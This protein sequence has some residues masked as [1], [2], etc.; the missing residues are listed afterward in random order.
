MRKLILLFIFAVCCTLSK[1]QFITGLDEVALLGT[2]A[3]QGYAEDADNVWSSM[4]NKR[5]SGIKFAD[6]GIT[7]IT[8]QD[9]N[10]SRSY[11]ISFYGY[12][13]GGTATGKYTLHFIQQA[14]SETWDYVTPQLNFVI[15]SFD[16]ESI[17]LT[18]YDGK[19]G[20]IMQKY[21]SGVENVSADRPETS[22]LLYD[23]NG[24]AVKNPTTHG[25]YIQGDGK[26]IIK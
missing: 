11:V 24:L 2:W 14:E 26:K 4:Q 8:V 7:S 9:D 5:L 1:A 16:S 13:I 12:I 21:N 20:V 6:D 22:S 19:H 15:T 10:A 18:S 23:F 25:I 17:T 3:V